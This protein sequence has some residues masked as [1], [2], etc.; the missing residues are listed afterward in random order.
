MSDVPEIN[1]GQTVAY[2]RPDGETVTA[3][4]IGGGA[5][6]G[7]DLLA[8][9]PGTD[10]FETVNRVPHSTQLK[11]AFWEPLGTKLPAVPQPKSP[12]KTPES[13]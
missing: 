2:T 4:V 10:L 1:L 7:Y 3:T 8:P 5:H 13:K 12:A 11:T 9:I 6:A